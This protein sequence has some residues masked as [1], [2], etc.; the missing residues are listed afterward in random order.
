M[1]LSTLKMTRFEIEKLVPVRAPTRSVP[2]LIN[3]F[4]GEKLGSFGYI[5][6]SSE[7]AGNDSRF[8]ASTRYARRVSGH[9]SGGFGLKQLLTMPVW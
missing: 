2:Y 8:P 1:S 9:F 5:P 7:C 4:H 6:E 3:T